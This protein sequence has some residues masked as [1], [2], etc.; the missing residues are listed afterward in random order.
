MKNKKTNIIY[1]ILITS[2]LTSCDDFWGDDFYKGNYS[3]SYEPVE[4]DG[5]IELLDFVFNGNLDKNNNP[6]RQEFNID[7]TNK[8]SLSID[9]TDKFQNYH[10]QPTTGKVKSLVVPVAFKDIGPK[11]VEKEDFRL[12]YQSVSS[13]FYNSSY[14]QLDLEF[15]V[16]NWVTLDKKSTYYNFVNTL[17]DTGSKG[18][19]TI[20]KEVLNKI[21]DS[22]DFSKYDANNDGYI[23]SIYIVYSRDYEIVNSDFWW[24]FQTYVETNNE[25][26]E[27]KPFNY[28]FAAYDFIF[29]ESPHT[30]KTFIHETGHLMGLEDYYDYDYDSGYE[31]GGVGEADMQDNNVGDHNPYT[32]L[33]L[34]WIDPI[35]VNFEE[36]KKS[37]TIGKY[38]TTSDVLLV[39]DNYIENLGVFQDYFLFIYQDKD[40][41]LNQNLI[42]YNYEPYFT[43]NG[44]RIYRAHS[45]LLNDNTLMYDNSYTDFNLL[46]TI[47][48]Y[49]NNT[50]IYGK[51]DYFDSYSR[52]EACDLDLFYESDNIY[53]INYYDSHKTISKYSFKVTSI[54]DDNATI[55]FYNNNAN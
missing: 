39:C 31:Y 13:F 52:L 36:D 23:D 22:I 43:K 44:I 9:Y 51:Q 29:D 7:N 34:N 17:D 3:S 46:D 19:D 35:L 1:F 24:A 48:N 16:L 32:K 30:A 49:K 37:Y 2:L 21:D 8:T 47:I 55:E 33:A 50:T 26:D 6:L 10:F 41:I 40:A 11:E 12:D 18:S 45:K 15:D 38:D 5:S 53:T 27:V 25:Y 54:T 4:N 42:N 14:G 28:V 20:V